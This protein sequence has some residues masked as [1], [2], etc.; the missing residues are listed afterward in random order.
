MKKQ[1][2]RPKPQGWPSTIQEQLKEKYNVLKEKF[3]HNI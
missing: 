1:L 2:E 3:C